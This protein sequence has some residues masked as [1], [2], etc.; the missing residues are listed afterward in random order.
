MYDTA[1]ASLFAASADGTRFDA[2]LKFGSTEF[3]R[4]IILTQLIDENRKVEFPL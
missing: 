1:Q 3:E 4:L 2:Q